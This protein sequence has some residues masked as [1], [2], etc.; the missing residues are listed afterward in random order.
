LFCSVPPARR[1]R[2]LFL[3][4]E[5][6]AKPFRISTYSRH[7]FGR[8][9]AEIIHPQALYFL[10]LREPQR[11]TPVESTLTKKVG[12]VPRQEWFPL[13][14]ETAQ[15]QTVDAEREEN[16]QFSRKPVDTSVRELVMKW[17]NERFVFEFRRSLTPA[18]QT[19]HRS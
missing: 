14:H 12:G 13:N 3:P 18:Q 7:L 2:F 6:V 10:Y 16:A 4:A 1:W 19:I 5:S 9:L 17:F 8:V 15:A 11:L